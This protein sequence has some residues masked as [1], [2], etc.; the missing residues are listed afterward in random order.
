MILTEKNAL[1]S[2]VPDYYKQRQI[3][4]P[5]LRESLTEDAVWRLIP[6]KWFEQWKSIAEKDEN[7]QK[8]PPLDISILF[9]K[10]KL[11][12]NLKEEQDYTMV[13]ENVYEKLNEWHG[14][15]SNRNY[16]NDRKVIKV[17]K[18]T[19]RLMVEVYKVKIQIILKFSGND[20]C[21]ESK[22]KKYTLKDFTRFQSKADMIRDILAMN[23]DLYPRQG[24]TRVWSRESQQEK[25][26]HLNEE[27]L[28][29][30][31][32]ELGLHSNG[33]ILCEF[34]ND[35]G[36]WPQDAEKVENKKSLASIVSSR[37]GKCGLVNLGNTCF[38]NSGIQCLAAVVPIANYFLGDVWK[39]EINTVNPLGTNGK[40][41]TAFARLVKNMWGG[42]ESSVAPSEVKRECG[43][44]N[45]Q[46]S[47]YGQN[48]SQELMSTILD[49]LHEDQ[50]RV[51]NKPY[52]EKAEA[53]GRHDEEVAQESWEN[54]TS[55][56][57]SV[58]VD[59]FHGQFK[60]TV[61]CPKCGRVSVTFDPFCTLSVPLPEAATKFLPLVLVQADNISQ[62]L[63]IQKAIKRKM[64][65]A[66]LISELDEFK[67]QK[68]SVWL[69]TEIYTK[70]FHKIYMDNELPNQ[71]SENDLI[72]MFELKPNHN[73]LAIY[74]EYEIKQKFES[75][76]REQFAH[77]F[78]INVP[79]DENSKSSTLKK[80]DVEAHIRKSMTG[81]L[82]DGDE[83]FRMQQVNSYSG[84]HG[85]GIIKDETVLTIDE[86]RSKANLVYVS[87]VWKNGE[88]VN[89]PSPKDIETED[90]ANADKG[91]DINQCLNLF[92]IEEKLREGEE[93]YCP[94]CKE[95]QQAFKHMQIWKLPP[96][97]ILHLK[98]FH[99]NR[100][101]RDKVCDMVHFPT[102][103]L[104]MSPYL[105]GPGAGKARY[106]LLAVSNHMGRLGG[107]HYT[108]NVLHTPT[109]NWLNFNDSFVSNATEDQ[110]VSSSAYVLVYVRDTEDWFPHP[111]STAMDIN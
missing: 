86:Y 60:S 68:D 5:A 40:L 16:E 111:V 26:R 96:V 31:L 61:R 65:I 47:G 93:W 3:V 73:P 85:V 99:Y 36:S 37:G 84:N 52:I 107:G 76:K 23:N 58:I 32:Y 80:A 25:W 12:E 42:A 102:R 11:K 88:V 9:E 10:N 45:T 97:L 89:S 78:M 13:P 59:N 20:T 30:S 57:A 101:F 74:L 64:T 34:Q 70:R 94:H 18:F 69:T 35:D 14:V 1:P 77:P 90:K 55:R 38:M 54:H 2:I 17:G 24:Q 6:F 33:H 110:S 72:V 29:Q 67:T 41:S 63:R 39:D 87:T 4:L 21:S 71:I 104:D 22:G 66:D 49:A 83:Q 105:L 44:I 91:I 62:P 92:T 98:R 50:N 108:A 100:I 51:I 106:N 8:C 43:Q 28:S 79:C 56:N 19:V 81:I 46:F 7:S 53:N 48:D 109:N 103:G 82:N 75:A 95:H 27:S 15:S